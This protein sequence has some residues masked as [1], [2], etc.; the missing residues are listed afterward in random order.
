VHGVCGLF[1]LL[2]VPASNADASFGSQ[3]LGAVVIFI[4]VFV[5]SLVVWA[6]LKAAMGIR[7]TKDEELQGMDMHDCGVEAY[8]EFV[9]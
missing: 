7:V 1:G 5:A 2:I 4:W 3:L 6:I 9:K 8:P